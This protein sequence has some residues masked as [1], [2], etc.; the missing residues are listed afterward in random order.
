M[1]IMTLN[2]LGIMLITIFPSFKNNLYSQTN[3]QN[4]PTPAVTDNFLFFIQR[5]MNKNTI[6]YELNIDKYGKLDNNKPIHPY[7]IRY[8]EGGKKQELSYIQESYAYGTEANLTNKKELIFN[9]T[10]VSYPKQQ[11]VLKKIPGNT[12]MKAYTSVNGKLIEL[13]KIFF[14]TD[15]G[16][17]WSPNIVY[18]D[19]SGIDL[20][21]GKYITERTLP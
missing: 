19:I 16:T 1:K 17:F 4:Y 7:W 21:T 9:I 12:K 14:K 6:A 20:K 2:L 3:M 11:I 10:L 18:I 13:Q 15:G 8:E 5:S